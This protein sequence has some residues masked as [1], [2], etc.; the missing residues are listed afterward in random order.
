MFGG[1]CGDDA[2]DALAPS[3]ELLFGVEFSGLF[4]CGNVGEFKLPD[5][6]TG[7]CFAVSTIHCMRENTCSMDGWLTRTKIYRSTTSVRPTLYDTMV[8]GRIIRRQ[9]LHSDEIKN[10]KLTWIVTEFHNS[11]RTLF[12][13]LS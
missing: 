2:G 1:C 4:L 3:S 6:A 7:E 9:I 10:H 5:L 11:I 12:S 13:E 8:K